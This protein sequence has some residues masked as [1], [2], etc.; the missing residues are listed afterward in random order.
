MASNRQKMER[1]FEAAQR[2]GLKE[3]WERFEQVLDKKSDGGRS[4]VKGIYREK[5]YDR[6]G[7]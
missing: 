6:D 5:G 4:I 1:L 3:D 2:V 7:P